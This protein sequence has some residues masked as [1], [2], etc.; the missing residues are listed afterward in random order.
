MK[1]TFIGLLLGGA[2]LFLVACATG[3][4]V[5]YGGAMGYAPE[6]TRLVAGKCSTNA[7]EKIDGLCYSADEMVKLCKTGAGVYRQECAEFAGGKD[8]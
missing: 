2:S 6:K 1:D 5:G 3:S 4:G 7:V 8:R